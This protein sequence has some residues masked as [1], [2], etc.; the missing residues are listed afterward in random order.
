[1]VSRTAAACETSTF[2]PGRKGKEEKGSCTV[3]MLFSQLPEDILYHILS[4][5]DVKSLSRLSQVCKL[6]NRFVNQDAVWRKIA[7][8]FLNTGIIWNG[9]DIYP[10]IP[11]KERVK[12]AQNWYYGVCKRS[13]PL[14]WKIKLLPWLQLDGDILFLSQASNVG[15]YHLH[16]ESKRFQRRPFEIYSGHKGDVCRFVVT[17]SHLISGGSDGKIMVHNR[18]RNLPFRLSGHCQEVNCLDSKD[19]IIISGSRD[20][21]ARIWTLTSSSPMATIPMFDRVWSVAINPTLR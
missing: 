19:R 21:T 8:E 10:H 14:K 20:R 17:A 15:A 12:M 3:T 2:H 5:L 6:M 9:T 7:R 11:L 16:H 4:F 1:M 13:T 18:R